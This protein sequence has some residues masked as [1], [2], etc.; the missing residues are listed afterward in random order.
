MHGVIVGMELIY[1]GESF[2]TI[3][4]VVGLSLIMSFPMCD[5]VRV[6]AECL[7]TFLANESFY[8]AMYR[9]VHVER[10]VCSKL[11]STFFTIMRL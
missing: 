3:F 4:T 1:V 6:S 5:E 10:G 8:S 11:F 2:P 9:F 7:S